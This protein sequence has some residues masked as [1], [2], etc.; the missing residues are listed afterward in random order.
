[1]K[2]TI[3]WIKKI[4]NFIAEN[5]IM[6]TEI[7]EDLYAKP[8]VKGNR[9]AQLTSHFMATKSSPRGP[10]KS[11]IV[12]SMN[13]FRTCAKANNRFPQAIIQS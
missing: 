9:H 13:P 8:M 11:I 1:M 2:R 12:M 3:E 4:L 5:N 6:L 10:I 7:S